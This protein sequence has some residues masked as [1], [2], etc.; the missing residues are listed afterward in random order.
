MQYSIEYLQI[1]EINTVKVN[2]TQL[3]NLLNA[4]IDSSDDVT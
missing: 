2:A 1:I 4:I 3:T